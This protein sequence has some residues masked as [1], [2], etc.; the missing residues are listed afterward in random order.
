MAGLLSEQAVQKPDQIDVA[1]KVGSIGQKIR[2]PYR[3]LTT[4][5]SV[6]NRVTGLAVCD[7]W[8]CEH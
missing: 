6:L 4:Q 1:L 2:Y 7:L 8:L 3:P 5:R